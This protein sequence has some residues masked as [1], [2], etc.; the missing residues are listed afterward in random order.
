MLATLRV[1]AMF[2][3]ALMFGLLLAVPAVAH[4]DQLFADTD[5]TTSGYNLTRDLGTVNPGA[6][7]PAAPVY[8]YVKCAGTAHFNSL[9]IAR[10]NVQAGSLRDASGN[11]AGSW[12]QD[13]GAAKTSGPENWPADG[14]ASCPADALVSTNNFTIVAPKNPGTYTT[15]FRFDFQRAESSPEPDDL[16]LSSDELQLAQGGS[17]ED[18]NRLWV[19]FTFTVPNPNAAPEVAVAGVNDGASYDK[20]SV[21]DATCDVTDTEDGPSSFAATLSAVTGP[22][23]TDGIGSQTASCSYKDRGGLTANASKTY[24]IVDS[25]KP[26]ITADVQGAQGN[27]GWYTD[28]VRI[29]W[30]VSDPES[31]N[32]LTKTGCDTT[33][34]GSDTGGTTLTCS[35]TSVG[36][37][38]SKS[39]TIK[40]DATDPTVTA[41]AKRGPDHNGWY[42]APF[43]VSF[44]GT[45]TTS[46]NVS[47][48]ASVTYSGPDTDAQSINGS[49]TDE[50][51]NTASDTF[52]FKYDQ[53]K[54]S[55]ALIGF[56]AGATFTLGATLPSPVCDVQDTVSG[57]AD[58]S[59]SALK[60]ADKRNASGFGSVTYTCTGADNAGN[61]AS[62]S[63]TFSV[64]YGGAS[65]ILQPI[66]PNNTSV[67]S[68]GRAVPVKFRLAGDGAGSGFPNG[69]NT[70]SWTLQRVQVNCTGFNPIDST[71]ES[72]PSN[73]PSTVFR[74]DSKA[75][76]Y[77]YNA[78]FSNKPAG[79]CWK[80]T[81]T[82]DDGTTQLS[83]AIFKLQK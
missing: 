76:Q 70:G 25:S 55:V 43:T 54:P 35:A 15:A 5:S 79:T 80:V 41:D 23:A 27:K 28:D 17:G 58:P 49:C 64:V 67:F 74:Y 44:S 56:D 71:R 31:P 26:N 4:A 12:F 16:S 75:D 36:G 10:L 83:S 6:T 47:C 24:S 51:G 42:N 63:K 14:D 69:F 77:I 60:T 73:T 78:D 20:G 29:T 30:N 7:A 38:D 8:F 68:R 11:I 65:G 59:P 39:V 48:D 40:R 52:D 66:N 62:V 3:L 18:A 37:T 57:A 32:S 34:I 72:V 53:G 13:Q 19:T 9:E 2:L 82:L 45:D 1:K 22:N 33:T 81:V 50:A 21:P 61:S 46:G